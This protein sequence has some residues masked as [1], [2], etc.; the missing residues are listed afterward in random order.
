[1]EIEVRDL[2]PT[3]P[4]RALE[5]RRGEEDDDAEDQTALR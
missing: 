5:C 3:Y 4:E 1:M 2:H